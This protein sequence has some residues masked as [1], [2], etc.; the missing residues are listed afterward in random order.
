MRQM[1]PG[2]EM[3]EIN[4]VRNEAVVNSLIERSR[5]PAG[6]VAGA[7]AG[8]TPEAEAEVLRS[9][10]RCIRG[11]KTDY[12]AGDPFLHSILHEIDDVV[13]LSSADGVITL[14]L[15]G[16]I[17]YVVSLRVVAKDR[18]LTPDDIGNI[19]HWF[20]SHRLND[21]K[22]VT[23]EID[24]HICVRLICPVPRGLFD[25]KFEVTLRGLLK[26]MVANFHQVLGSQGFHLQLHEVAPMH[27][28]HVFQVDGTKLLMKASQSPRFDDMLLRHQWLQSQSACYLLSSVFLRLFFPR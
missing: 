12:F 17:P 28:S 1:F 23:E 22:R 10:R 18:S 27:L 20:S 7:K 3:I 21:W 16:P 5:V 4:L 15:E 19:K 14:G 2:V 11:K 25:P 24:D 8:A 9:L 26:A 13:K 6:A